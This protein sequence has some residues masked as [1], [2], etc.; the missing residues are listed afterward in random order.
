MDKKEL[1]KYAAMALGAYM[2][3][4]YWIK[5]MMAEPVAARPAVPP[6]GQPAATPPTPPPP[7]PPATST[8]Q[9]PGMA[10]A[11]D[12]TK[13]ATDFAAATAAPR[14]KVLTFD[15]WN[16]YRSNGGRP[17]VDAL[18]VRGISADNRSVMKIDAQTYWTMMRQ[19]D[20]GMSGFDGG[21]AYAGLGLVHPS[22][23]WLM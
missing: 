3:Y 16:Y 6:P 12:F 14:D 20:A 4:Q 15:E 8:A 17:I 2:V 10:T 18:A 23:A 9:V 7:Q 22:Y 11:A 5:P 19:V 21:Y 13:W 1:I